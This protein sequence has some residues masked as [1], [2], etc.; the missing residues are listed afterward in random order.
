MAVSPVNEA[1]VI[2]GGSHEYPVDE[3][4]SLAE[5]V[6]KSGDPG[7]VF[8]LVDEVLF[9]LPSSAGLQSLSP[10]NTLRVSASEEQKSFEKLTP[11]FVWLLEKG[12]RR[13]CKLLVIGGGVVQDI[14]CFIASVL[15]R[16]VE[17]HLIPTTLLAQCDSC[18]GSKSSINIASFKNQI[19]TFYPPHS[20]GVVFNLLDT[21]PIDEIRSGLGEII[22]LHLLSSGADYQSLRDHL[23]SFDFSHPA[24]LAP[25]IRRCLEIKKHYIE[26]DE[27]D[28]GPRNILNY[29]HTFG[30]AYESATHYRIPHGIAVS[31]G[32]ATATFISEKLGLIRTGQFAEL[33]GFLKRFY[34]PYER[35][36]GTVDFESIIAAVKLD[37]KNTRGALNCILTSGAGKM[38]KQQLDLEKELRPLL[39]EFISQTA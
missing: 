17:W 19:G 38:A 23:D 16:G 7:K 1:M 29:G 31:L 36:L 27:F 37:K 32:V 15:F 22:K 34:M 35:I 26:L 39:A 3:I 28:R 18:I 5:A 21:L 12:F 10:Q 9:Q 30:H 6:E 20:V 14:G 4:S 11:L 25:L 24:R 8:A 13:D 2:R 33:D